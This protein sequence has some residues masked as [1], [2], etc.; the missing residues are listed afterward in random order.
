[1]NGD[2]TVYADT[3]IYD[4]K[5][6]DNFA[7]DAGLTIGKGR[8]AILAFD[9]VYAALKGKSIRSAYIKV[10]KNHY[11]APSEPAA[12]RRTYDDWM[13]TLESLLNVTYNNSYEHLVTDNPYEVLAECDAKGGAGKELVFDITEAFD[14]EFKSLKKISFVLEGGT[15]AAS[16]VDSGD[17]ISVSGKEPCIEVTYL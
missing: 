7:G 10:V 12:A 2:E 14:R 1:M 8:T 9:L 13:E 17:Y 11:S 5:P 4:S 15:S 3:Y 6:N 16:D